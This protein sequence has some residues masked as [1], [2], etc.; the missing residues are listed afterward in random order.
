[1]RSDCFHRAQLG[2]VW[3]GRTHTHTHTHTHVYTHLPACACQHTHTH[4]QPKT[5]QNPSNHTHVCK[6]PA[7]SLSLRCAAACP[8]RHK[9]SRTAHWFHPSNRIKV[10]FMWPVSQSCNTLILIVGRVNSKEANI[11]I[12][13]SSIHLR[14]ASSEVLRFADALTH[15]RGDFVRSVVS[16]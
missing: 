11:V 2:I 14:R 7:S 12:E 5:L 10:V 9:L 8:E 15:G 3:K 16:A 13:F 1:M 6:H 4:T